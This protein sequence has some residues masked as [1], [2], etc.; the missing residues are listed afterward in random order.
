M[1]PVRRSNRAPKPKVHWEPPTTTPRRRPPVFTIYTDPPAPPATQAPGTRPTGTQPTST[2]PLSTQPPKDP[3]QPRFRPTNRAGKPQNLPEDTTPIKLFQLFF[4]VKEIEN[5]VKQTNQRAASIGFRDPWKPLT[6]IE[7][8][9]YLR[10][11]IY[12]GVQ[13]LREL[14]DYWQ[15]NTPIARCPS[16]GPDNL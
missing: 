10:C 7:A 12:M 16:R 3:Y 13:P 4:T 5:I 15:L 8:Y 6:T 9:H 1:P 2:Q 11:L 14:H